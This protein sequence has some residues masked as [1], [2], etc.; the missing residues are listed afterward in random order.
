MRNQQLGG[1]VR[2]LWSDLIPGVVRS[3]S[4]TAEPGNILG[5]ISF[6]TGPA[7]PGLIDG[8][9]RMTAH[10][11]SGIDLVA[12]EIWR[13]N[14]PVRSGVVGDAAFAE[15]G[16]YLFYA[17]RLGPQRA[18]RARVCELYWTALRFA[19]EHG[20]TDLVRMWNLIGGIGDRPGIYED[21]RAGRAE[22]FAAW[23]QQL[24][25]MPAVTEIG[26]LSAGVDLFFLA[27]KPGRTI[28]VE[29]PPQD[30]ESRWRRGANPQS[31]A[32]ATYLREQGAGS[33]F[34][35]SGAGAVGENAAPVNDV[36]RQTVEAL[37]NIDELVG[38]YNLSRYGLGGGGYVARDM[39]QVKVYVR[40]GRH[41]PVVRDICS[42]VFPAESAIAYFNVDVCRPGLLVAIEG[43]CR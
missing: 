39:D 35:S 30:R 4:A 37:R 17:A 43:V 13:T 19:F 31:P 23:E 2:S 11:A 27:T 38:G 25:G 20:Y 7:F 16:E 3:D 10:M 26:T 28:Q 9:P 24:P 41:V 22:A 33:L 12:E 42:L 36:A 21:C 34:I 8:A 5:R 29:T 1:C 14:L 6:A 15:D 40:D 18:Y 32:R